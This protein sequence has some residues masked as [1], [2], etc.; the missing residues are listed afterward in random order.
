MY[1]GGKESPNEVRLTNTQG[2][3][4]TRFLKIDWNAGHEDPG[5][6]INLWI[7]DSPYSL[8]QSRYSFSTN[9]MKL[10]QPRHNLGYENFLEPN[11][12]G[13]FGKFSLDFSLDVQQFRKSIPWPIEIILPGAKILIGFDFLNKYPSEKSLP[14]MEWKEREFDDNL[15]PGV[16]KQFKIPF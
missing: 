4:F 15:S 13:F 12:G 7:S 9:R 6:P 3:A 5:A 11:E 16:A 2:N 8:D 1:C 10:F 14:T